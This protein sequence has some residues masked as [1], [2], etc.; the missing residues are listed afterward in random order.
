MLRW[1]LVCI[2]LIKFVLCLFFWYIPRCGI[3]GSYGSSNFSF[4]R[5]LCAVFHSGFTSFYSPNSVGGFLFLHVLANICSFWQQSFSL[6]FWLTFLW[7][8][9]ILSI[10]FCICMSS[11]ENC[12]FSSFAHFQIEVFWC[13]ILLTI[14]ICWILIH[15]LLQPLQYFLPFSRLSFYFLFFAGFLCDENIFKFN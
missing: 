11:L 4:L 12:L 14:Y 2:Y 8:L 7:W 5:N 3:A 13:C 1:T 6:W 10:F 15:H 9:V